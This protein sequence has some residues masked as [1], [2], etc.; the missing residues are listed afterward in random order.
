MVCH[1]DV[2]F[3]PHVLLVFYIHR[4]GVLHGGI[5]FGCP[6][7]H[8]VASHIVVHITRYNVLVCAFWCLVFE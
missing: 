4:L 6:T 2:S 1:S 7:W 3:V 5:H 8:F